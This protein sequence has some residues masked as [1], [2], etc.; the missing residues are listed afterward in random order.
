MTPVRRWKQQVPLTYYYLSTTLPEVTQAYSSVLTFIKLWRVENMAYCK[1]DN[2]TKNVGSS[3][4]VNI[5]PIASQD[6]EF[7]GYLDR[8]FLISLVCPHKFFRI[9]CYPAI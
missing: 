8:L 6:S 5:K 4:N 3:F 7:A 9:L 2:S 1:G